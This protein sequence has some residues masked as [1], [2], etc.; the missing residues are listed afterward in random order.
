[1]TIEETLDTLT[2]KKE[3]TH[4][5]GAPWTQIATC[6][7]FEEAAEARRKVKAGYVKI[8][9]RTDG[10]FTVHTRDTPAGTKK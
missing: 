7:T 3:P 4:V 9:R 8:R 5:Q 6:Q 2:T 1:M 10:T